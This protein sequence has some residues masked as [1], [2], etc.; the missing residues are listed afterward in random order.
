MIDDHFHQC[1][2][3]FKGPL[4]PPSSTGHVYILIA[5]DYFTKWVEEIP[6]KKANSQ[7]VCDFLME[8]IFVRFR[9][10]Q[11]IVEDNATYFSYK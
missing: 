4:N 3:D 9:V 6:T 8:F 11:K 10:P 1:G 2:I 5:I 7:V